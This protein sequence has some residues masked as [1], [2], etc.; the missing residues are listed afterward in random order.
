MISGVQV[1]AWSAFVPGQGKVVEKLRE[2][3]VKA[4]EARG[5]PNLEIT[6][7]E[8][9]ISDSMFGGLIGEKRE[10]TFFQQK[11]GNSE[12]LKKYGV[13]ANA[14]LALRVAPRGNE[15]LEISW[16]LLES[17]PATSLF[18]GLS[19]TALIWLGGSFALFGLITL[20]FGLGVFMLPFGIFLL[21]IGMGWWKGTSQKSRLTADQMLD[22]RVLGQTVD[23]CLMTELDKLGVSASDLR[24]LQAAQME[25][26]G[27]LGKK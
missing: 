20:A 3:V 16:R 17:N 9:A 21:G 13:S 25:G 24:I 1:D 18:L 22:A 23:Y 6:T 5:L 10:Y 15:D 11:F 7:G 26:I 14:T 8:M 27:N 2:A 4:V 19:Q 12:F